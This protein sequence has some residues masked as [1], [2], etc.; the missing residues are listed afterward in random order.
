MNPEQYD[1]YQKL[2][3]Q[4]QEWI[5]K[6]SNK[7]SQL[8]EF[9][10]LAPDLFHLL[11][12][13]MLDKKVP[14]SKKAK[15]AAAIVYFISPLDLI[16]EAVFGPIGYLDDV[17][18][19]ALVLNDLINDIDPKI[20]TRNWAGDRDVLNIMKTIIANSDKI[21]GRSLWNKLVKKVK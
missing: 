13:L 14:A 3:H 1:F 6:K 9:V 15:L 18:L 2:R 7:N 21:I 5:Q 19:A 10:L 16:P 8:A 20:V 4:I 12:K 11:C 17:V